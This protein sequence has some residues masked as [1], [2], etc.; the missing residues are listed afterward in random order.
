VDVEVE[1]R[2][3][4]QNHRQQDD[5]HAVAADGLVG[6]RCAGLVVVFRIIVSVVFHKIMFLFRKD[7]YFILLSN[8]Y[9]N[10]FVPVM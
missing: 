9:F 1:D 7:N 5:D 8:G 3:G 10:P 6:R 2:H 4:G